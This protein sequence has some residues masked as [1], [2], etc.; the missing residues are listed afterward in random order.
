[1][2]AWAIQAVSGQPL[3]RPGEAAHVLHSLNL[4]G[5]TALFAAFTGVLLFSAS[6]VAGWVE[7]WFVLHHLESSMRFNP[8]II[9]VLGPSRAARWASFMRKHISGFASNISLGVMLGMLPALLAFVGI[10][11]E[12]RHVTLSTGQIAGAAVSYGLGVVHM[13]AFWLCVAAIP[14]IGALNLTVS[15][16]LAFQLALRAQNVGSPARARI[17]GAIW[18]R[19]LRRPLSFFLPARGDRA[20]P[21]STLPPDSVQ[22]PSP[23]PRPVPPA[24]DRIDPH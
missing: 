5:P 13:P 24:G 8:G 18:R 16:A 9:R 22:P 23:P 19:L 10:G 4:L 20:A 12:A 14:V 1:V 3:V 6:I 15:F 21:P 11:L 2:L 7:N 17:R